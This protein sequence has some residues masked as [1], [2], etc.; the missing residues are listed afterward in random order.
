MS[1]MFILPNIVRL[2]GGQHIVYRR[3]GTRSEPE[4]C[5][6]L[7]YPSRPIDTH[8][9]YDNREINMKVTVI[10]AGNVGA[11]VAD[12]L[13]QKDIVNEIVLSDSVEGKAQ[14]KALEMQEDERIHLFD[15]RVAG[16]HR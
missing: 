5:C 16:T 14:G 8:R 4:A 10:G 12:T 7:R 6:R 3:P 13:A 11:T 15:T 1:A 9:N 2:K